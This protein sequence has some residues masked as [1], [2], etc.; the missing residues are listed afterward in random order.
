MWWEPAKPGWLGIWWPS[1]WRVLTKITAATRN[2]KTFFFFSLLSSHFYTH[3]C[4]QPTSYW[5]LVSAQQAEYQQHFECHNKTEKK[6]KKW[7]RNSHVSKHILETA[8]RFANTWLLPHFQEKKY[9]KPKKD[10]ICFQRVVCLK[11]LALWYKREKGQIL[12]KWNWIPQT[13]HYFNIIHR[14][15]TKVQRRSE[16]VCFTLNSS[17]RPQSQKHVSLL[18]SIPGICYYLLIWWPTLLPGYHYHFPVMKMLQRLGAP[19]FLCF[20]VQ[21]WPCEGL[22]ASLSVFVLTRPVFC[23]STLRFVTFIR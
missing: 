11:T 16:Q 4:A 19:G 1:W 22:T 2:T 10:W 23:C 13:G 20:G 21:P 8:G 6:K 9:E 5:H 3:T 14:R 15:N 12:F 17:T 7:T 18:K